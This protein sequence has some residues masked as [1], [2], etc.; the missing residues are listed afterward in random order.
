MLSIISITDNKPPLAPLHGKR[1]R[2]SVGTTPPLP[3]LNNVSE[4]IGASARVRSPSPLLQERFGDAPGPQRRQ[5][6]KTPGPTASAEA[7]IARGLSRTTPL[8]STEPIPSRAKTA[9]LAFGRA[10]SAGKPPN[11]QSRDTSLEA[12]HEPSSSSTCSLPRPKTSQGAEKE[13]TGEKL[14]RLS[15]CGWQVNFASSTACQRKAAKPAI[16][17]LRSAFAG[18]PPVLFFDYEP[19]CG[20][21]PRQTSRLILEDDLEVLAFSSL[22][23]MFY[24]HGVT[25][26]VH[27]YK[28]V[29]NTL[30]FNGLHRV[31]N[32]APAKWALYWGYNPSPEMLRTFHP[33]QKANH[34]PASWQLGRKDLLWRNIYRAKRQFPGSSFDI[35]PTTFVLPE[36]HAAWV[37]AREQH[38]SAV[39]I[40]KPVNSSCGRGIR[41]LQ[42]KV[43]ASVDETL[44]KKS[45]VAQTYVARPLLLNGYKFD[46]RLYVVVTS[47]DPLKVYLNSEGL[48]RIATERYSTNASTLGTRTMHLTNYSVN[49]HAEGYVKNLD[50][51]EQHQQPPAAEAEEGEAELDYAAPEEQEQAASAEAFSSSK[52][53]FEE[54]RKHFVK[55]GQ[56]YDA[57]MSRIKDLIIKT[58]LAAEP[59][60]LGVLH[61]GASFTAGHPVH[62]VGPNQNCFEVFGFDVMVDDS[63]KPWLLE[64]NVFPSLSSSSPLDKRI[65]TKL[66]ADVLTLVGLMPFEH[67]LLE[68]ALK[69]TRA[70]RLQGVLPKAGPSRS[71]S[72]QALAAG[73]ISLKDFGEA[74]WGLILDTHDEYLRRGGLERIFPT[75]ATHARYS[76]FFATPRYSNLVLARWLECGGEE[77]LKPEAAARRPAWVPEQV[78][79]DKC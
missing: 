12:I 62:Q 58:L 65:K 14:A 46:L 59:T 71:F 60:M 11:R 9:K 52:W 24:F 18:R 48:V 36:E 69:D 27:E 49:K 8:P 5:R 57:M 17:L 23:K 43:E 64:V 61:T 63:F 3:K 72:L 4:L 41:L 77:T 37:A 78:H 68:K 21:A 30:K 79:F 19:D 13:T 45:G 22:P 29:L 53:S 50:G 70:A 32:P 75:E 55:T 28:A 39:W 7:T 66:I 33:F 47:L 10:S 42:S 76:S 1:I 56:D 74:E 16:K 73:S 44:T 25:K 15:S 2:P 38:P 34:F 31:A 40:W 51:M 54:L 6:S 67:D 26:D 35:M 20:E